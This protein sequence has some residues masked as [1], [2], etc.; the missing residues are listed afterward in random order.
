MALLTENYVRQAAARAKLRF[1]KNAPEILVEARNTTN[2][3]FDI[4]LSH[5]RLDSEIVLGVK[6]VLEEAGQTVY[7]DWLDDPNLDRSN[8][9]PSTG[10]KLRSRMRQS[11]SMFYVHS[12][13]ATK[14]RWMP[15]ELGYFDGMNGNVAILP[16]VQTEQQTSFKGEEYLGLYPYVDV[17]NLT[18]SSFGTI[19]IHKTFDKY[20]SVQRWRDSVDKL[21]PSAF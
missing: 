3:S 18:S 15:W 21:R 19:Y 11:K 10:E 9:T 8:V 12:G 7:V 4:F 1:R 14:S 6:V 2:Q 20:A 17:S 5:S 16:I 13:N